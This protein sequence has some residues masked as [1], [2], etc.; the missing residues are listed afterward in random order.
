[1]GVL[2]KERYQGSMELARRVMFLRR[3]RPVRERTEELEEPKT[4][5]VDEEIPASVDGIE[6]MNLHLVDMAKEPRLTIAEWDKLKTCE[7]PCSKE[8]WR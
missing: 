4:A 5:E 2:G 1:M 3:R 7:R 8:E 6:E